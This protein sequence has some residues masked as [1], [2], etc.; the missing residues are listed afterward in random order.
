MTPTHET[1]FQGWR[2]CGGDTGIFTFERPSGYSSRAGQWLRL[3][4]PTRDGDQTRTLSDAAAPAEP[5]IDLAVRLTG[6]P[7]KDAMMRLEPGT[8]VRFAGPGGTLTIP[9]Q[10]RNVAFLMGGVGITPGR[11]LIRDRI[12]HDDDSAEIVLFYGNNE[13]ACA[14]FGGEFREF[15]SRLD[16]FHLIEVIAHPEPGWTGETGFITADVVHRHVALAEDW[17]FI[18]AGPPAMLEPMKTVLDA[19][20]VP[21]ER[22]LFESF[23]GYE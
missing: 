4:L 16:W 11:A 7:F 21:S 17:Y 12:L 22:R 2:P 18:V 9:E 20:A 1:R 14:P 3:T 6:S 19:L 8:T 10:A 13:L 5:T 15:D 23:A